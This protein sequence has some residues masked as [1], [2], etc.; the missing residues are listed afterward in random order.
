MIDQLSVK[1]SK[2][3]NIDSHSLHLLTKQNE[4]HQLLFGKSEHLSILK[5]IESLVENYL[6]IRDRKVSG[7]DYQSNL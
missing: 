4:M 6:G 2:L 1:T 3:S 5:S 7:E